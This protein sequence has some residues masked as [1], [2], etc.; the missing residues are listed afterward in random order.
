MY[1]IYKST[2]KFKKYMA[3]FHDGR[4]TVHFGDNRY[5]QFKDSTRLKLY[6]SLNHGDIERLK[7]YYQRHGKAKKYSAKYFSHRYLW[8]KPTLKK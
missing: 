6:A 4:P 7:R 1:T 3:V 2:R 8:E 5:E